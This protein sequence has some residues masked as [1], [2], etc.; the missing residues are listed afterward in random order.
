M[1]WHYRH[2]QARSSMEWEMADATWLR[3][4]EMQA[5]AMLFLR[6]W[7]RPAWSHEHKGL[8]RWGRP[9]ELCICGAV[10]D[11]HHRRSIEDAKWIEPGATQHVLAA[12]RAGSRTAQRAIAEEFQYA[13]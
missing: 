8:L 1:K 12:A 5:K 13:R 3:M 2:T 9:I 11:G 4:R 6:R 7:G 10:R